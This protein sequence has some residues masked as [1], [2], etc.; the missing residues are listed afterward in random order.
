M[1][2]YFAQNFMVLQVAEMANDPLQRT[3]TC[4]PVVLISKG[5]SETGE[6]RR[7]AS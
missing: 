6:T 3:L 4:P 2:C 5:I 1:E 7:S